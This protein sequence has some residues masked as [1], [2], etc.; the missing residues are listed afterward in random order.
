MIDNTA[1]GPSTG[2]VEYQLTFI[3]YDSGAPLVEADL[4]SPVLDPVL[5]PEG[6]VRVKIHTDPVLVKP[7]PKFSLDSFH[8][9][10]LTE[11]LQMQRVVR[12]T[13][14]AELPRDRANWRTKPASDADDVQKLLK[15]VK[16]I[17]LGLR[18]REVPEAPLLELMRSR[19][20]AQQFEHFVA[21]SDTPQT[22]SYFTLMLNCPWDR[23]HN[24]NLRFRDGE[25]IGLAHE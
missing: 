8:V 25:Y 1:A 2:R 24:V 23:E 18:Q 15:R 17:A 16:L 12:A 6:V 21:A 20:N 19:M 7:K 4:G 5:A 3:D 22:R 13:L 9:N 10:S 11:F 14:E